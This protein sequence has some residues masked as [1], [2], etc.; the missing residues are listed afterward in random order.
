M[1]VSLADVYAVMPMKHLCRLACQ[2]RIRVRTKRPSYC[3]KAEL[4]AALLEES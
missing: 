3:S 1:S 2:R 4:I